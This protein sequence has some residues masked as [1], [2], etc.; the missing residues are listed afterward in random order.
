VLLIVMA[1]AMSWIGYSS[2]LSRHFYTSRYLFCMLLIWSIGLGAIFNAFWQHLKIPGKVAV[3]AVI[4]ALSTVWLPVWRAMYTTPK[5]PVANVLA[6]VREYSQPGDILMIV[7]SAIYVFIKF[8]D[9]G[10]A[11]PVAVVGLPDGLDPSR[12]PPGIWI[13]SEHPYDHM[14][15][16]V[17]IIKAYGLSPDDHIPDFKRRAKGRPYGVARISA[18]GMYPLAISRKARPY[19]SRIITLER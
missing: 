18:A 11:R 4:L 15:T 13:F 16:Y 7:P 12:L 1:G 8:Y 3:L 14:Y 9:T 5:N 2:I 19:N 10:N 17:R 6:M